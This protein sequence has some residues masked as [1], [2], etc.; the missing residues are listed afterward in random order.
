MACFSNYLP[1]M[2]CFSNYLPWSPFLCTAFWQ[3]RAQQYCRSAWSSRVFPLS[4]WLIWGHQPGWTWA[5]ARVL[6]RRR[7]VLV[8]IPERPTMMMAE[9]VFAWRSL[10][11]VV[12]R[13]SP[14]LLG[15]PQE[16]AHHVSKSKPHRCLPDVL[17]R[18]NWLPRAPLG[19]KQIDLSMQWLF[20]WL[21][22]CWGM[23]IKQWFL[24]WSS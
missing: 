8:V 17:L 11:Q 12:P 18:R 21:L 14:W 2:A 3:S 5:G 10:E 22:K 7:Q 9:V 15:K 19:V 24:F 16:D 20:Y 4:E 13:Q 6:F 1:K 23:S